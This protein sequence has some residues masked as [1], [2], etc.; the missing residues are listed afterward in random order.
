MALSSRFDRVSVQV[1]DDARAAMLRPQPVGE[2]ADSRTAMALGRRWVCE[3]VLGL[4]RDFSRHG[5]GK[6]VTSVI[7][8]QNRP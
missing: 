6:T 1:C 5:V 2:E 4:S 8:P 3:A 7:G